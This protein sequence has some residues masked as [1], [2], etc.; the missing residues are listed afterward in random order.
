MNNQE[1]FFEKLE[2]IGEIRQ[3]NAIL[4]KDRKGFHFRN[5]RNLFSKFRHD[6]PADASAERVEAHWNGFV[7]NMRAANAA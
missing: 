1:T 6:L 7:A 4:T 5:A 2:R 3:G